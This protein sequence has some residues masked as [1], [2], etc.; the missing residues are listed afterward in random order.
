LK[1]DINSI[2]RANKDIIVSLESMKDV[3]KTKKKIG[4]LKVSCI[5]VLKVLDSKITDILYLTKKKT[6]MME[7]Q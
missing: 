5:E 3:K 7:Y 6:R 1:G 4:D 2:L